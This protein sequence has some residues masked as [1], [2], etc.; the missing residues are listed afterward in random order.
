M[1]DH[2]KLRE[3]FPGD[4]D[5]LSKEYIIETHRG[6]HAKMNAGTHRK[7]GEVDDYSQNEGGTMILLEVLK[8]V[9][10][11]PAITSTKPPKSKELFNA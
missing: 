10:T 4:Y 1:Y 6:A 11:A 7:V 9:V 2:K 3:L 5:E 8:E